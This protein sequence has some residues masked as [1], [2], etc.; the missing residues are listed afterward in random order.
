M[1]VTTR[2]TWATYMYLHVVNHFNSITLSPQHKRHLVPVLS[3]P[4][5]LVDVE[6]ELRASEITG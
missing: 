6:I 1:L 3:L 4:S 2:S 5:S